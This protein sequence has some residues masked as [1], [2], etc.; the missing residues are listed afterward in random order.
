[1]IW[2]LFVRPYSGI[3]VFFY[4]YSY[5]SPRPP[6][7][8]P[9][10]CI[11]LACPHLPCLTTTRCC[12]TIVVAFCIIYV[13]F[14]VHLFVHCA[15]QQHLLRGITTSPGMRDDP[16]VVPYIWRRHAWATLH[17]RAALTRAAK[18]PLPPA[19]TAFPFHSLPVSTFQN[20]PY[21]PRWLRLY[22][23]LPPP[24]IVA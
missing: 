17:Y 22:F 7:A 21:L 20:F 10:T 23:A 15:L 5:S 6:C 9:P 13:A 24:I 16:N 18:R 4:S 14:A 1:M 12:L 3:L 8:R 19:S 2:K 11:P